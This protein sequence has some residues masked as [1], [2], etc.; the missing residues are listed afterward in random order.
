[1]KKIGSQ[2]T[3]A[4]VCGLLGFMLTYQFQ[5]LSKNKNKI[6]SNDYN[7][8]Q[9]TVE[10]EQLK[11]AK[12]D[13]EKSNSELMEQLKKYEE[14]VTSNGDMSREL[15][16]QLDYT[17]MLLGYTDVEGPGV[18]IYINPA[19]DLFS[20]DVNR[21][22]LTHSDLAYLVNELNFAGAE[23]IAINDSRITSQT[24]MRISNGDAYIWVNEEKVSPSQ[25]ITIKAIGNKVNLSS[26]LDFTGTLTAGNLGFYDITYEKSDSIRIPKYNKVYKNEYIKPIKE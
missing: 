22:L 24:G 3:V 1:M 15:K 9:I 14:S 20:A 6:S 10:L 26:A 7:N 21:Q 8:T 5:L 16:N 12:A 11:K 4:V 13:L 18:I 2:L 23:A 19:S 17:R 25:R